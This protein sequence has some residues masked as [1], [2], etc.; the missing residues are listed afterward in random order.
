MKQSFPS[1]MTRLLARSLNVW[2]VVGSQVVSP[3]NFVV[4]PD[5]NPN[6]CMSAYSIHR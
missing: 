4:Y 3:N 6:P 5:P 2:D 1:N